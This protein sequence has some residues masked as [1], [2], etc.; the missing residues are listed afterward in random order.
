MSEEKKLRYIS[1]TNGDLPTSLFA[2]TEEQFYSYMRGFIDGEPDSW[3]GSKETGWIVRSPADFGAQYLG[4]L[5]DVY[6][7]CWEWQDAQDV[8]TGTSH[9]NCYLP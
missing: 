1:W 7:D 6:Q 2:M 9:W 3:G 4:R 5:L 8:L